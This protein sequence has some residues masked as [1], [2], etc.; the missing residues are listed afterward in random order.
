M[1]AAFSAG[2][3]RRQPAVSDNTACGLLF[4]QETLPCIFFRWFALRLQGKT[5]AKK[6]AFPGGM[7]LKSFVERETK[8]IF[9]LS[10]QR[11]QRSIVLAAFVCSDASIRCLKL[12]LL[13]FLACSR[14]RTLGIILIVVIGATGVATRVKL[15]GC[16]AV[17]PVPRFFRH[18]YSAQVYQFNNPHVK[19][20]LWLYIHVDFG[21][22]VQFAGNTTV[23]GINNRSKGI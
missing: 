6:Q 13:S 19:I 1:T 23:P 12:T 22:M 7:F 4:T 3:F 5:Y 11:K 20:A 8:E 9:C 21:T 16:V 14:T 15:A 10:E 18:Y 17:F 2:K